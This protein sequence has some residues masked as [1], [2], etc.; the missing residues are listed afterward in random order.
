MSQEQQEY[1]WTL[2]AK[3]LS[4]DANPEEL[5]E[6][7]GL[8]QSNPGL[9]SPMQTLSDMWNL[10]APDDRQAAEQAFDRHLGRMQ[11]LKTDFDPQFAGSDAGKAKSG[12]TGT[13]YPFPRTKIKTRRLLILGTALAAASLLGI[14][15][16]YYF[17]SLIR[18]HTIDR[19]VGIAKVNSEVSTR[20]G[21]KTHL[22]LPDGTLVWLNAGSRI[23]YDKN[24][25]ITHREISL[26]GEAFFDVARNADRPFVIHTARIDIKVLGTRFNVRSYPTD[27][28]TE[29]T[30][31]RGSIEVSIKDR[32]S[33]KIILKPDEKLVVANDDS[34]LHRNIPG[35][36][37]ADTE[38]SLV[39]IRKPTYEP[40]TGAV[41]ET[42]WIDNKLIFQDEE[43]SEL[44]GRMERWYGVTI[45]FADPEAEKWRFTGTFQNETIQQ[46]LTAMQLT[47]NF[48]YNIEGT[49][50]TV[51]KK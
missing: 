49:Q 38:E 16:A 9:H 11:E 50:I 44:A 27:K 29:T 45:R 51:Y 40:A 15:F 23:I 46:E 22:V 1:I 31:I 41:I 2:I 24:F 10:A 28:T 34:T 20:N 5:R 6:L 19:P 18:G 36:K 33:E 3:K 13:V 8:L 32:P 4:G 30:L 47:A 39:T 42:S 43:F 26:T 48:Y 21:S 17:P 12:D 7:E 14:I 35:R 37:S 25:G